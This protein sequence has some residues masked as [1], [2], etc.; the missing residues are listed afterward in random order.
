MPNADAIP[1][2]L[3]ETLSSDHNPHSPDLALLSKR[4]FGYEF[5]SDRY[6]MVHGACDQARSKKVAKNRASPTA[7]LQPQ[8]CT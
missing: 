6:N 8:L 4:T 2:S 3:A 5:P 1:W 7:V